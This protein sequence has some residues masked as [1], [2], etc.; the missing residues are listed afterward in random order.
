MSDRACAGGKWRG[1]PCPRLLFRVGDLIEHT[2]EFSTSQAMPLTFTRK[3]NQLRREK[4]FPG[5]MASTF[6][7]HEQDNICDKFELPPKQL[8]G[9]L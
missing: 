4:S 8:E 5:V 3:D 2:I 9:L 7:L 1:Q 6:I